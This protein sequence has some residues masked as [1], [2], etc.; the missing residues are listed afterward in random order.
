MSARSTNE[1]GCRS[2]SLHIYVQSCQSLRATTWIW[3]HFNQ[4]R[5]EPGQELRRPSLSCFCLVLFH[6][7]QQ[8]R[9][10]S[11]W[12]MGSFCRHPLN[13]QRHAN[14]STR[15]STSFGLLRL[16]FADTV[17]LTPRRLW[18]IF[19]VFTWRR[20]RVDL[21][22]VGALFMGRINVNE[23]FGLNELDIMLIAYGE[24]MTDCS[25]MRNLDYI[26]KNF[27]AYDINQYY[28]Q[29]NKLSKG[30]KGFFHVKIISRTI[31][32]KM[33]RVKFILNTWKLSC[34]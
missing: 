11:I 4:S 15:V 14:W 27:T 24:A 19:R 3:R 33:K 10:A 1:I 20:H 16:L 31:Y 5:L 8:A 22:P 25:K 26:K 30:T 7:L 28:Q 21:M 17:M 18:Q 32:L 13:S 9:R 6:S 29:S 12:N 23:T 2:I 34:C